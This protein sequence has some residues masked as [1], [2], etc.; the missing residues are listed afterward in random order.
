MR[1][2]LKG[3]KTVTKRLA[4]GRVVRYWYAWRG[5][6][7]LRGEPGSPEF[8]ASYNAA[9]AAK[10]P[11][12]SGQLQF[13]LDR[14]QDSDAFLSLAPRTREDYAKH[15]RAISAEF[16]DFPIAGLTDRKARGVFLDWRDTRAK[17]SRRQADYAWSVLARALSWG[18][19][20]GHVEA[21]PCERG[22]RL[23]QGS[24]AERVWTDEDEAAFI[25]VA[26]PPLRMALMLA[27]WT[28]QRQGD[29]LRL[30]WSAYDGTHIR[31]QQSKT[32][33]RVVVR[34]GAPLKEMLD[35]AERRG[36]LILV[37][38]RGRAWTAMASMRAGERPASPQASRE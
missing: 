5:G 14:F 3:L 38:T 2:R 22:G 36:Q 35:A 8:M 27:L 1:V 33:T 12:Q 21:N 7:R 15:L 30:S 6:P 19:D 17:A 37:N 11:T 4:D 18:L 32:D 34:A 9:V 20:R 28:G 29:L 26:S 23:Y 25:R 16:G 31:L 13:V 10:L 24:R